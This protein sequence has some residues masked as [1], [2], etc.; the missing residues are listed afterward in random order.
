MSDSALNYNY[1][2]IVHPWN[3]NSNC[4]VTGFKREILPLSPFCRGTF[5]VVVV[6]FNRLCGL[7]VIVPG[8]RSRVPGFD[9]QRYQIFWEVVGLERGPFSLVSA[10]EELLGRK[11]SCSGLESREYGRRVPSRWP[12]GTVCPQ[13]LALT[14]PTSGGRSVGIV[15]SLTKAAEFI[16]DIAWGLNLER[17]VNGWCTLHHPNILLNGVLFP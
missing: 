4:N 7:V 14:S 2:G 10:I 1:S 11:R 15:R 16:L 13:K 17:G 12:R 3:W 9:S 8:Y 5:L 6:Y